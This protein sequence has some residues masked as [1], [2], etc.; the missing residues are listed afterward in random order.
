VREFDFFD[1]KGALE[2][3]VDALNAPPLEFV[4]TDVKHLRSGQSAEIRLRGKSIGTI[5]RLSDEIASAYKFRQAVF[6]AEIDLETLLQ[7]GE[8]EILYRPLPVFPS[9]VRDVSFL[10]KRSTGFAEIKQAIEGQ[11]F[12]LLRKVEFVDV[13]EGR[14][15]ADDERSVTIRFEY[16]SDERTLIEEE[17]ETVHHR[18]LQ[19]LESS[20]GVKQRM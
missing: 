17:V 11:G 13:Y 12:E 1:A 20:F 6:V 4:A 14:G 3:A 9:I 16:R 10:V 2:S 18:M 7:S 8:Q 19:N 5:G 15:L